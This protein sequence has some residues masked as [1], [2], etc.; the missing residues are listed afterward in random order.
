MALIDLIELNWCFWVVL[1]KTLENPLDNKEIKPVNPK[2]NQPWIF[3]GR[4]DAR[5]EA[6]ILWSPDAKNQFTRKHP[7]WGAL[8]IL[9]QCE[10]FFGVIVLQFLGH[11]PSSSM[12]GLMATSSKRTYTT[13]LTS[14]VCCSQIPCP[15]SRPLLTSASAGET[16]TLKGRAGSV[17]CGGHCSFP[18]SWCAQSLVLP[19]E[20]L[21]WIWGLILNATVPLQSSVR[22]SLLLLDAGYLF[23]SGILHSPVDVCS[24]TSGNFG[25]FPEDE[26]TSFYSATFANIHWITEKAREFQKNIYFCFTDYA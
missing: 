19:S 13:H 21:L 2:G 14:Q 8:E 3:I 12:V 23:F 6:P 24:A 20:H 5:V 15:H 1:G 11:L 17:S 18:R 9:H 7:T 26:H 22:A 25:A 4:T 10:N 16:Q